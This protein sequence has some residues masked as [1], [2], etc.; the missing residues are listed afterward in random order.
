MIKHF[1]ILVFFV[2]VSILGFAQDKNDILKWVDPFI[3]TGG[4]GHTFPGAT[5]P[6]G[7]IQLSPDQNTKSGDW[8]WCSGYHYSSKTI[9][10]FSHNHL[11]GTGWADL[12]DILV[13]PTTGKI[14]MIA[15]TEQQPQNTYRSTFSHD[16]ESASPGYYSVMLDS[17]NVKAELTTSERVGFHKYTFPKTEEANIIIDPTNKIYGTVYHTAITI[18]SNKKIIGYSYSTGWGGKRFAY[19][20]MEFSKPF[21]SSGVYK[22][23]KILENEKAA[24]AKDAKAYVRFSTENNEAIEIKVSL[25][26]ISIEN[27]E[28][29]LN[30]EAKNVDFAKAKENVQNTWRK[31]ISRFEVTGGTDDQRKI[32][33]TGVYHTFIAPNLYMDVNGEYVA[34]EENMMAKG[35]RNYSTFSYWDGFRATH[36]LLTIMDQKHTT[37]FAN[38]LISRH[39][40]RKDHMPIWELTGYDNFCMLGYHSVSVIWDAISKGVPGINLEDAFAAMKDA[41]LTE[42]IKGPDGGI[43]DYLKYN[44]VPSDYVASVSKTLEY[45]Y[46][47]W[48]IAQLALKLGKKEEAE[49]YM[50]RSQNYLNTFN[51]DNNHFWPRKKDGKFVENFELNDWTKLQPHWVSGNIWAYDLF[52]PQDIPGMIN[53]YGGKKGF[54]EKLDNTFN[55][56]LKMIGEQ[57]VDISGF[58]G[59]LGFGDEPGHHVPYLYNYADVP[60]KT[61]KMVKFIRDNMYHAK[62]D[63]IVN[64]ED[65]GQMSAWYI[66]SSLGFYPVT[67]GNG[68]YAIGT[69]QFPKVSLKLENG[70]TFTVVADKISDKNFYVQ[71]I[72]LNGKEH[73]TWE[74]DHADIMKGGELKFV[75]GSKPAN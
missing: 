20:V 43:D 44:Y 34:A 35:F 31:L 32:F 68:K 51:K 47:D 24:I 59:S 41:S 6:F 17:Y 39:K 30:A 67:P 9:M 75:I 26:P 65:C 22:A 13:M 27:A 36:P 50:K 63:G 56:D 52:V 46:D 7:M 10:G 25:S 48:C 74:L 14:N 28:E 57:H 16:R 70:K 37:E 15:G 53:L 1:K 21:K 73:K 64:N 71:K 45:A 54:E 58:I 3:G 12:G 61:Q 40:D 55:Q 49:I 29:N 8:D 60:H 11:S 66:F 2:C 18:E 5:S 38:S 4:H 69:P 19:F 23:G 62:P 72:F 33:Y 42:K